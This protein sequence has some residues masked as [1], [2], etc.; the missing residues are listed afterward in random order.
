MSLPAA[1]LRIMAVFGLLAVLY[2][3]LNVYISRRALARLAAEAM[4]LDLTPRAAHDLRVLIL[5]HSA[6]LDLQLTI[7]L[8]LSFCMVAMAGLVLSHRLGGPVYHLKTYLDGITTGSITP[9]DVRFRKDDFFHDLAAA[10]N[11]FQR[12]QGLVAADPGPV[13]APPAPTPEASPAP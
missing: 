3:G 5:E 2:A 10:F 9:R 6:T 11:R 7:F 4:N 1:Q 13:A 8:L 12:H